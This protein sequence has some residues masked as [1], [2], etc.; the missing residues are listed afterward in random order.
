MIEKEIP[1]NKITEYED[2]KSKRVERQSTYKNKL[3]QEILDLNSNN[4]M[5]D[6]GIITI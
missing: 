6:E 5:E 2:Q 3:K 4:S 1:K